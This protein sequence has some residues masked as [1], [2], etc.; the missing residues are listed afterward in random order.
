M[1][2]KHT[3]YFFPYFYV[4]L[5]ILICERKIFFWLMSNIVKICFH[6]ELWLWYY[7]CHLTWWNKH[8]SLWPSSQQR[9]VDATNIGQSW[10]RWQPMLFIM[11]RMI[12]KVE[13]YQNITCPNQKKFVLRHP[14]AC[15]LPCQ[16]T[17]VSTLARRGKSRQV[18]KVPLPKNEIPWASIKSPKT[19]QFL[20]VK[21]LCSLENL[22]EFFWKFISA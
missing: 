12:L 2:Q 6:Q 4:V 14:Q 11:R 19:W 22:E 8:A 1:K 20:L 15:L 10:K 21:Y 5:K 13:F 3:K 9:S 17:D 18:W 16:A 7:F